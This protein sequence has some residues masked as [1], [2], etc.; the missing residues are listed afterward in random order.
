MKK[1][2]TKSELIEKLDRVF[3][4]FIRL[5]DAYHNGYCR[6][7]TCGRTGHWKYMQNGHYVS[8]RNLNTRFNETNCHVQCP[9]CNELKSGNMENYTVYI[10]AK[11]GVAMPEMLKDMGN[12]TADFTCED[13]KEKISLYTLKVKQLK[14]DIA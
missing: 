11:Y 9:E 13:L 5:R 12:K 7:V 2:L 1:E 3:S 14:K 8:R 6:C 4:E 10:A